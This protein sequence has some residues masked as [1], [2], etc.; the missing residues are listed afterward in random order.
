[1]GRQSDDRKERHSADPKSSV[2][3]PPKK[4]GGGGKYTLGRVGEYEGGATVNR[5]DPNYD[6]DEKRVDPDDGVAYKYDEIV[7]FYRGKFSPQAIA[8]YWD[9][10]CTPVKKK[11]KKKQDSVVPEG[12]SLAE[13]AARAKAEGKAKSAKRLTQEDMDSK[14]PLATEVAAII[15]YFPFK[16]MEKF[17]DVQG[18]LNHPN[19]L[20]A[21]CALMAKRF[22]KMGVTKLAAFEAKGLIFTPVAIKTGLPFIMLRKKGK[23]PNA[24][25]SEGGVVCVQKDAIKEGDK[26]ILL[27][28]VIATGSTMCAGIELVKSLKA[29]VVECSSLVELKELKGGEKCVSAGAK[30]AWSFIAE[31]L[32]TQKANLPDGY[33]DDAA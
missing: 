26:V 27:D 2:R 23:I 31:E 4:A 9:Y 28:D 8:E 24:I 5:A 13:S 17:Y 6:P 11:N 7:A 16:K 25:S 21:V 22:R 29:V 3:Q 18:L 33:V 14:G 19:L 15:P 30:A 10:E 12:P 20:N 1:M 32:L